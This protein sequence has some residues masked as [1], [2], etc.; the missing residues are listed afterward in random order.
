M[1]FSSSSLLLRSISRKGIFGS[2]FN[3][4]I[5]GK[6]SA[7]SGSTWL[8]RR[9]VCTAT[10]ASRNQKFSPWLMLPPEFES[11][12]TN[13][14]FFSIPE[15]KI[16]TPIPSDGISNLRLTCCRGSSHGWLAL[17][18][19]IN[20]HFVL[21]NPISRNHIN[22]PSVVNLAPYPGAHLSSDTTWRDVDKLILSSSPEEDEENCR[23]LIINGCS[24]ALAFCCPMRSKEWTVILDEEDPAWY[25]DCVYS[26]R[27]KLFFVRTNDRKVQTWDLTDL[28]SPK[29]IRVEKY[30]YFTSVERLLWVKSDTKEHL[31]V[32]GKDLL[33]VIQYIFLSVGPDS[34]CFY[35]VKD[36]DKSRE[37]TIR[38]E[39]LKYDPTTKGNFKHVDSSY[40]GG[41]AIFVGIH[42]HAFAVKA[43][44]ANGVKPNSIYFTDVSG[45]G[46]LE[47]GSDDD[48]LL[49]NRDFG[50]YNYLDKTVSHFDDYP[51]DERS[52][53]EMSPAPIWFFPSP[54][55]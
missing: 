10:T 2:S 33:L 4:C 14:K 23:A 32:A 9:A 54:A 38:F 26:A 30:D 52:L 24:N 5:L 12:T 31:V 42:S 34:S 8:K 41:L 17:L 18:S 35:N 45:E 37:M 20:D 47:G 25:E 43:T 44:R 3:Y 21:Y 22:L 11:G 40:L 51:L 15:N 39:I 48:D 53:R 46:G 7:R 28:S 1:A 27:L 13:Y 16:Q 55:I 19:P 29:R 6:Q 49:C 50:I 36:I